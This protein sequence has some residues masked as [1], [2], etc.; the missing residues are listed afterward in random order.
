MLPRYSFIKQR[1]SNLKLVMTLNKTRM[2]QIQNNQ[3]SI[4]KSISAN[5]FLKSQENNL[6]ELFPNLRDFQ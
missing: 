4:G 2:E 5:G 6:G 3:K 1:L